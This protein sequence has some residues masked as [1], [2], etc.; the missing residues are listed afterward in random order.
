MTRYYSNF[1]SIP[2]QFDKSE[3]GVSLSFKMYEAEK[4]V[5]VLIES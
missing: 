4:Q 3:N 5:A 1:D 2:W